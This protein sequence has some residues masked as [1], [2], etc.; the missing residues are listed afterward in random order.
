M[1]YAPAHDS[2]FHDVVEQTYEETKDCNELTGL[3]STADFLA[4]HRAGVGDPSA[5]WWLAARRGRPI[6]VL[7]TAPILDVKSLEIVYLGVAQPAR[8]TGVANAL[9][10]RAV[11]IARARNDALLMLGV[12]E[13]NEPARR[14]YDRWGFLEA[15]R[16]DVWIAT[17]FSH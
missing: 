14:L 12:D 3:R 4:E 13:R 11:Q 9:L 5:H 17:S 15:A 7:L 1:A 6:G 10:A 2:L 8:K 16:K